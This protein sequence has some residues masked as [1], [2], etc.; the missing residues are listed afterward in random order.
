MIEEMLIRVENYRERASFYFS[1]FEKEM[2]EGNKEKA[3]EAL[4][5]VVSCLVNALSLIERG[6]P[7]PNHKE[8]SVFAQQFLVSK[9]KEGEELAKIYRTAEKF[10]ANF[11][12]AF[13]DKEE[14]E[15]MVAGIQKLIEFLDR[16]LKEELSKIKP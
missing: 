4:W 7:L 2:R 8:Q 14:F 15:N 12:H 16:A 9:F 13:L 10:H 5:G 3:G 1:N 6:K 11:Y